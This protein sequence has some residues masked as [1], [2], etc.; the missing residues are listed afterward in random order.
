MPRGRPPKLLEQASHVQVFSQ[1]Y[2]KALGE[3]ICAKVEDGTTVKDIAE[4]YKNQGMVDEAT[5][6]R[7]RKKFPEFKYALD[8]AYQIFF[9]RKID[10]LEELSKKPIDEANGR[11]S[12]GLEIA[13]RKI[14]VDALKFILTKIA[15][16]MC[17]E[18]RDTPQTQI[19]VLPTINIVKYQE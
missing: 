14:R 11:S 12:N 16:K 10:E 2:T 8:Q 6:Y 9:Y 1:K 17:S 18:L 19:A 7:W 3:F 4:S 13:Q 5:I 15:P